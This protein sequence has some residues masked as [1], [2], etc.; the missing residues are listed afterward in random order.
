MRKKWILL[1]VPI[2]SCSAYRD[3]PETA[4]GSYMLG[5]GQSLFPVSL[6]FYIKSYLKVMPGSH[7]RDH[8][9]LYSCYNQTLRKLSLSS[10]SAPLIH[11]ISNPVV[12]VFYSQQHVFQWPTERKPKVNILHARMVHGLS[13]IFRLIVST[14][15]KILNNINVVLWRQ[16]NE[17]NSSLPSAS[18]GSKTSCAQAP[19]CE[20]LET[21]Y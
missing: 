6:R 16:V 15:E 19:H 20:L 11:L 2:K 5:I 13:Q 12:D 9:I 14:C 10:L 17:K 21:S 1:P 18:R 7:K 3:R 4:D 8:V